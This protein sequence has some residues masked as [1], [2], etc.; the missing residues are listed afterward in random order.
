MPGFKCSKIFSSMQSHGWGRSGTV[1]FVL[2]RIHVMKLCSEMQGVKFSITHTQGNI[3][4]LFFFLFLLY[5]IAH[6][7]HIRVIFTIFGKFLHIVPE[8]KEDT[9]VVFAFGWARW[10]LIYHVGSN[11][12]ENADQQHS[13]RIKIRK[14][15]YTHRGRSRWLHWIKVWHV[16]II[17]RSS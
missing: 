9:L 5:S 17:G 15:W 12:Y 8:T 14:F 3:F 1:W 16:N 2:V 4:P 13:F 10:I 7:V 6:S 11:C